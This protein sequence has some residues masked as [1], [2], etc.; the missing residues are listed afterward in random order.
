MLG[1]EHVRA[2]HIGP[3]A[4]VDFVLIRDDGIVAAKFQDL[5]LSAGRR[6][7]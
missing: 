2:D 1:E 3:G 7:L 5:N 6:N 4:T